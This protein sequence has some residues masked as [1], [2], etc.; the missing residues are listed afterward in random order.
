MEPVIVRGG[1]TVASETRVILSLREVP[2]CV[3]GTGDRRRGV[4]PRHLASTTRVFMT[5]FTVGVGWR[6]LSPCACEGFVLCRY[7]L[8]SC[9]DDHERGVSVAAVRMAV[10]TVDRPVILPCAPNAMGL[11]TL[12][13]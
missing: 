12:P 13:L 4:M 10:G 11:R 1:V 7:P 2:L 8:P 9:F 3:V 5:A 6:V